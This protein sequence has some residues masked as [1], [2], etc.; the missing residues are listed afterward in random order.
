MFIVENLE[1]TH[2]RKNKSKHFTSTEVVAPDLSHASLASSCACGRFQRGECCISF[3]STRHE[4]LPY[5]TAHFPFKE[6]S[7]MIKFVKLAP[8][9]A[10]SEVN[11]AHQTVSL[12]DSCPCAPKHCGESEGGRANRFWFRPQSNLLRTQA[13]SAEIRVST[14]LQSTY[15]GFENPVKQLFQ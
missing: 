14:Y 6:G 3:L 13:G 7:D 9:S 10:G 8:R 1:N 4:A 12:S 15:T 11:H 2:T 5:V